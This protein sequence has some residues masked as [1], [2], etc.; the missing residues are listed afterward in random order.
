MD[1]GRSVGAGIT[2]FARSAGPS[3]GCS[4][5]NKQ[6]PELGTGQ[7]PGMAEEENREI[8][9]ERLW[10]LQVQTEMMG[11]TAAVSSN[12]SE[13]FQVAQTEPDASPRKATGRF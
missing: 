1:R 6:E 13:V 4:Q 12:I 2:L 10:H 7:V 5:H 11:M 3:P 9:E 8:G